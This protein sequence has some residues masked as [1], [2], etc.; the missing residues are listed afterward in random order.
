[1]SD[2]AI[3]CFDPTRPPFPVR[4]ETDL[5]RLGSVNACKSDLCSPD[6]KRVAIYNARNARNRFGSVYFR[7][8]K[9]CQKDGRDLH[10]C[11]GSVHESD[12]CF[13]N[14]EM[15]LLLSL[16]SPRVLASAIPQS[17]ITENMHVIAVF[18]VITSLLG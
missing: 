14:P 17:S 15:R 12:G 4:I 18:I 8:E 9:N 5:I 16:L 11:L 6:F 13:E 2:K 1:M 7:S 10:Q 3:T